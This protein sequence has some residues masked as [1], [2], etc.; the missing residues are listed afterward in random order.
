MS[1]NLAISRGLITED[2]NVSAEQPTGAIAPNAWG[3]SYSSKQSNAPYS[4]SDR[5]LN[6]HEKAMIVY[7]SYLQGKKLP[8]TREYFD[9]FGGRQG[10]LQMATKDEMWIKTNQ[11]QREYM[12]SQM[13]SSV[14]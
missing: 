2:P 12:L 10:F 14:T 9:S 7:M 1:V 4:P 13:I 8:E 3:G 6:S 5:P 11:K